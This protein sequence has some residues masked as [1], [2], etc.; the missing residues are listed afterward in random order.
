MD[1]T[2]RLTLDALYYRLILGAVDEPGAVDVMRTIKADVLDML[3]L[4]ETFGL[5]EALEQLAPTTAY[6]TLV[7]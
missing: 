1:D 7:S 6:R 5:D 2:T 4:L 3:D